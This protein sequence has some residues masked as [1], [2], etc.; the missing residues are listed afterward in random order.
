MPTLTRADV[1]VNQLL[2]N[3]GLRYKNP[4]YIAES[5]CPIVSVTKKSDVYHNWGKSAWFRNEARKVPIGTSAPT[6]G[7]NVTLTNTYL[8]DT[9]KAKIPLS[10]EL[11]ANA[12]SQIRLEERQTERVQDAIFLAREVR[13]ASLFNTYTNWTSYS[14]LSGNHYWDYYTQADSDPVND[15]DVAIAAVEDN[16]AGLKANT[17]IMGVSVWRK[18]RRHPEITTLIFGGGF[19]GS[20]VVTERLFGQAFDLDNVLIGR[21]VYTTDEED[22]DDSSITYSKIWGNYC[23]IGH[24]TTAPSIVEPSAAYFFREF[25][26]VRSW[27]DDDTDTDFIEASESIDEVAVSADC[28]YLYTSPCSA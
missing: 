4:A 12:D 15:I 7:I 25:Y 6:I 8:C 5:A 26:R 24:V 14:T 19:P 17:I 21:A 16:S 23:W 22:T 1:H 9:Y 27:Y 11:R 28:G 3:V 10:R 20:K 2:T 18:L 13:A